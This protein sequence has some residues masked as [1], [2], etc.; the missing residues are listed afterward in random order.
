MDVGLALPQYDYS[1]PAGS[2]LSWDS[3][4][5]WATEAD[6]L[7]LSSLWLA[8]HLTMSIEKYGGP[9]GGHEGFEPLSTLAAVARL[10]T[11]ARLGTLVICAPFRP[12]AVLAKSVA[13][14][15]VI[16]H[17]RVTLGIGAGWNEPE[18]VAAGIPFVP[19]GRRLEHL[20]ESISLIRAVWSGRPDAPP[21]IPKPVQQPGPPVWIGGT[22]DR[23]LRL[24]ARHGDGW[25]TAWRWTVDGYRERLAV[26][27]QACEDAGRDPATVT[28]SLGLFALVGEDERDLRRRYAR[29]QAVTPAGVVDRF[30]LSEWREGRLVGTV[31]QVRQQLAEWAG[32][33]VSTVIA[34]LGALP[35]A[36]TELDDLQMLSSA[37][38]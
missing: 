24:V 38:R 28:L 37:A 12:P 25:N 34:N 11:S 26:L 19:P 21:C 13:T 7:G 5:Q 6:R 35:F 1:A 10:T 17:G 16:S 4:C 27:H 14:I 29:L 36:V 31:D 20:A 18:F 9:P 8:D 30:T 33:G 15:D 22:G 23:L 32:V 3:V 2:R